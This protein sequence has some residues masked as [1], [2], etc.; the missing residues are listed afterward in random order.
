MRVKQTEACSSTW[1]VHKQK[2]NETDAHALAGLGF[3]DTGKQ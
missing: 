1:N 2:K 3:G